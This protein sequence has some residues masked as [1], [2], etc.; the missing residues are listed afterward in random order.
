MSYALFYNVY[1]AQAQNAFNITIELIADPEGAPNDSQ[2]AAKITLCNPGTD[3][4][5]VALST[6][7]DAYKLFKEEDRVGLQAF[8][9]NVEHMRW[10][11]EQLLGEYMAHRDDYKSLLLDET[12]GQMIFCMDLEEWECL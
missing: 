9:Q 6:Y 1:H 5:S 11:T 12:L 10:I 3:Q 2:V 8:Y 4:E 7:T